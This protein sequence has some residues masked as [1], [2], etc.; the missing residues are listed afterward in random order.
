MTHDTSS[1]PLAHRWSGKTYS[2]EKY[3]KPTR[4]KVWKTHLYKARPLSYHVLNWV[5]L[6]CSSV[7]TS[8][9][10]TWWHGS[11]SQNEA[12]MGGCSLG[13]ALQNWITHEMCHSNLEL[14]MQS[15]RRATPRFPSENSSPQTLLPQQSSV[16]PN[17]SFLPQASSCVLCMY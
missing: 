3:R 13:R 1:N 14:S 16:F 7:T 11:G 2:C 17:N 4:M 5:G 10:L 6:C 12:L 15:L 8:C 9:Y